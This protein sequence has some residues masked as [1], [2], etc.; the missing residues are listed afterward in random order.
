[1]KKIV[2]FFLC[3]LFFAGTIFAQI[4]GNVGGIFWQLYGSHEIRITGSGVHGEGE[5]PD[6]F[7]NDYSFDIINKDDI[8]R[9]VIEEGITNIGI[10]AFMS[11]YITS[12]S[13]PS[14]LTAIEPFAFR[15]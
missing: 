8:E 14:S 4:N 9:I 12:I 10:C 2:I 15:D 5:I 11:N 1:M 6:Y 13:I 3:S 7:F